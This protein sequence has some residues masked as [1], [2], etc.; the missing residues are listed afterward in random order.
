MTLMGFKKKFSPDDRS[1]WIAKVDC[2]FSEYIR[3]RDALAAKMQGYIRCISCGDIKHWKSMD[4]GHYENRKFMYLRFNEQNCN[5][6]C[7]ECNRFTE[8]EKVKY[9]IGLVKKIGEDAVKRLEESQN[10]PA[11]F[12]IDGLKIKY[13]EYKNKADE[14]KKR[15]GV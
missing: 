11:G 1:K 12:T 13:V 8:G 7:R 5:A 9:R 15:L 3:L 10:Y 4:C 6:Q 14:L 2:V